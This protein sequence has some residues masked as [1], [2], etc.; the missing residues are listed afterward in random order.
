MKPPRI[1]PPG[2][3][4]GIIG[5]GQLGRMSAMAAAALGYK[6]HVFTPEE[7]SPAAQVANKIVVADYSDESQLK[8]F[9]HSVDV[10]T[11]EFEN[12]P[13]ESL[14][15]LEESAEVHP[16][17]DVLKICRNRLREKDFVA[18]L[19]IGTAPYSPV[20]NLSEALEAVRVLKGPGILKTTELGYD[21]KG[22]V[23]V[24]PGDDA[25]LMWNQL[26][27][28]EAVLEGF[29]EFR[30][31][32]SVIVARGID[33]VCATYDVVQNVHKD[34]ILDTTT[35]PAHISAAVAD[36]AKRIAV[37]IAEGIKLRGI[38]AVEMFVTKDDKIL[39]NEL[40]PRPHNSGHWSIDACAT[41]QFEQHI[42]AVCGLPLGATQR[43]CDAEMKNL[44]GDDALE[45]EKHLREPN[46]KLHLYGKTEIRPGRKMGHVTRLIQYCS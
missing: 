9:A 33:G 43:L 34:H 20:H 12:V 13:H 14:L 30:M 7:N 15:L 45:W 25:A 32:I 26:A 38:L 44:I 29:V 40:A 10:I 37:K 28:H 21:G 22:Q 46:T 23:K 35:V 16:G 27:T 39:V 18:S 19:G 6:V 41:S 1:I 5:G 36:E 24:M 3:T 17:A 31:E 11:F 42:R 2:S 8:G 4:I